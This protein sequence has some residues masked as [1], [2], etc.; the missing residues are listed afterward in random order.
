MK[1]FVEPNCK[2][3]RI[4]EQDVVDP[5]GRL[6]AYQTRSGIIV[7]QSMCPDVAYTFEGEF[8]TLFLRGSS[9]KHDYNYIYFRERKDVFKALTALQEYCDNFNWKLESNLNVGRYV[10]K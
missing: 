2:R 8:H 5:V 1:I 3:L 9:R 4:L 7:A 6:G 10:L